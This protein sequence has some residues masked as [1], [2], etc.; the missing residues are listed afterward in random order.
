M[1]ADLTN[2]L[3]PTAFKIIMEEQLGWILRDYKI[4]DGL[5]VVRPDFY[6]NNHVLAVSKKATIICRGESKFVVGEQEFS[7]IDEAIETLGMIVL[8]N[9]DDWEWK[10]EKEWVVLKDNHW[11][12]SFTLLNECPFRTSVRC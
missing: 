7:T 8:E 12:T 11:V 2:F 6:P 9:F 4:I 5:A 10:I 3:N 1:N